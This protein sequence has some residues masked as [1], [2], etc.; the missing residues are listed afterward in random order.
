VRLPLQPPVELRFAEACEGQMRVRIDEAGNRGRTV[1]IDVFRDVEARHAL[2]GPGIHD[3]LA[4]D[5]DGCAVVNG[6]VAHRSTAKT[7]AAR[8]SSELSEVADE[9]HAECSEA[10]T[11]APR[12][13]EERRV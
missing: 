8:G 10:S 13:S 2:L 6:E 11:K 12:R 5:H 4:V 9:F 7:A 1:R 3:P